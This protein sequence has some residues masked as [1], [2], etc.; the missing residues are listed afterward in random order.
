MVS[1]I[2]SVIDALTLK[3]MA[4]L[5]ASSWADPRLRRWRQSVKNKVDELVEQVI[6]YFQKSPEVLCGTNAKFRML[7]PE[8]CAELTQWIGKFQRGPTKVEIATFEFKFCAP[9]SRIV[10]WFAKKRRESMQEQAL[11]FSSNPTG[12]EAAGD[13]SENEVTE[14]KGVL[15]SARRLDCPQIN[16]HSLNDPSMDLG[17]YGSAAPPWNFNSSNSSFCD[18]SEMLRPIGE[19]DLDSIEAFLEM[20]TGEFDAQIHKSFDAASARFRLDGNFETFAESFL[21]LFVPINARSERDAAFGED[22][23]DGEE[24]LPI[25]PYPSFFLQKPKE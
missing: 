12:N 7:S 20:S 19:D 22:S 3:K 5:L 16:S 9:R 14:Y 2:L 13:K 11:P 21:K 17:A 6:H 4:E 1:D 8:N 18:A 24:L 25:A 23:D 15:S 10:T